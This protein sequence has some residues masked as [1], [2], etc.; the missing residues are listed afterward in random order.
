MVFRI[1]EIEASF[2]SITI[3]DVFIALPIFLGKEDFT[4][5]R[6]DGGVKRSG[7]H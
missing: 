4:D 5:F 6:R 1:E 7:A 3:F 2:T